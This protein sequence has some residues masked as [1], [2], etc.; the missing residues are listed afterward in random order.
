LIAVRTMRED[1]ITRKLAAILY[2]DVAGY[3]R[4][5]GIDEEATH[6][7]LSVSL[8]AITTTIEDHGGKVLHYAGDAILAEFASAVV[9]VTC[10]IDIQRDLAARNH[11]VSEDRKLQFR[12]GVNLGDVIADR[13]ELYGNGVN[14]AARLESLADVGGIC[15]SRKVLHEVRDKLEVGFESLGDQAV[16][17]IERPIPVYRVLM[18]PEAAGK[19][20]G[21]TATGPR[22]K[23]STAV[24][25]VVALTIAAGSIAWWQPWQSS[26]PP[27]PKLV[28]SAPLRLPDKPS[29]AV[30]PFT[31]MSGDKE[32][33]YF[34]DGMTEDI[35]T[36]LSKISGLFIIARNSTF[37]YKGK[38]P[39][40]RRVAKELGVRYVLEG[41]IRK[42]SGRVRINAQLIDAAT[43]GHLWADRYDGDLKD[44]FALQDEVT[45]KIVSALAV[46]LSTG[47]EQRLS[48]AAQVNPEAYDMLLRGL[49]MLRRFT[50]DTN[51]EAQE[52]FHKAIALDPTYARAYADIALSHSLDIIFGWT[53]SPENHL[54]KAFEFAK[55]ALRLDESIPQVH[56]AL[57]SVYRS[58][59]EFDKSIAAAKR[60]VE[61]DPNYADGYANLAQTLVHAGL[62]DEGIKAISRAMRLNPRHPFFYVWILGHAHFIARRY[63]SAIT[64]S[65][66]VLDSNPDFPGARRTLAAAYAHQDRLDEAAWE[67]EEILT[68]DPEFTL[69]KARRVT[70]YKRAEDMENYISGLRKAGLPE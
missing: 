14:V 62:A 23:L 59:Q 29:I 20:L 41:S 61:L 13:G 17:N 54:A 30:L 46:K 51:I 6:R 58:M 31:N 42:A 21:E 11:G 28:E 49:E 19:V 24:A 55:T 26:P 7:A 66:R 2:T 56:F 15:I 64:V 9:A 43:G 36:D 18:D 48:R 70:P 38:S 3:S 52:F 63:D 4:L 50:R 8:D 16:K 34:S 65:K 35:I 45:Q 33:E 47:E 60:S 25:A 10:A 53:S 12:I 68:R 22:R 57:T 1:N 27:A 67:I 40:I 5:T 32:Q 69:A 37:A 44:V 39:D